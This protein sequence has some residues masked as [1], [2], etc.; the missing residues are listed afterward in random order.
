MLSFVWKNFI[1]AQL[2]DST[3]KQLLNELFQTWLSEEINRKTIALSPA[4]M[5]NTA[6]TLPAEVSSQ[7]ETAALPG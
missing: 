3:R 4:Q 7:K 1:P 2:N 6:A 5:E